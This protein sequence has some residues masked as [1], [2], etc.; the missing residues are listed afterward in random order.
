MQ[1]G[2]IDLNRKPDALPP[3][4]LAGRQRTSLIQYLVGEFEKVGCTPA[5]LLSHFPT[6]FPVWD[7]PPLA[8][9][10]SGKAQLNI[11]P[12]VRSTRQPTKLMNLHRALYKHV[13]K[14]GLT[15][16]VLELL[17]TEFGQVV[18]HPL[19]FSREAEDFS[20]AQLLFD[21]EFAVL[22][23]RIAPVRIMEGMTCVVK[24]ARGYAA[25][26]IGVI[27]GDYKGRT[28]DS[29]VLFE[30]LHMPRGTVK[31]KTVDLYDRM[32]DW[33]NSNAGTL[34]DPGNMAKALFM[35][36]AVDS[37][38]T[39][40]EFEQALM[41]IMPFRNASGGLTIK[42]GI[43]TD[44]IF[45]EIREEWLLVDM[46]MNKRVLAVYRLIVP[47]FIDAGAFVKMFGYDPTATKFPADFETKAVAGMDKFTTLFL[48][49]QRDIRDG[50][51]VGMT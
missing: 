26:Y 39:Y 22:L 23:Q 40:R 12:A 48:S 21:V 4:P 32:L 7:I 31:F 41:G 13:T 8:T 36:K 28:I 47:E 19:V 27:D 49:T 38:E 1:L 6:E 42:A 18:L 33:V 2:D 30:T 37:A 10:H 44:D 25:P 46:P 11:E 45:E 16:E 17:A 35:L 9:A 51:F 29:M 24:L 50:K 34:A 14:R 5:M 43:Y 15:T 20:K 3:L